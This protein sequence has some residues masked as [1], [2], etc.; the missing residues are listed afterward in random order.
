MVWGQCGYFIWRREKGLLD[1]VR[2]VCMFGKELSRQREQQELL[3]ASRR[4]VWLGRVSQ[5]RV[6]RDEVRKQLEARSCKA[7][8]TN[9]SLWNLFQVK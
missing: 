8:Q 1:K 6:G 2:V 7:L 9:L 5:E 3:R 4:P